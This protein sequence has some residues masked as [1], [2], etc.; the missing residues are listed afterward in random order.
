MTNM[1][2]V[3]AALVLHENGKKITSDGIIA[4]LK[5]AGVDEIDEGFA[6]AVANA[7][8]SVNIE[9]LKS[10]ATMV[11]V[12][13]TAAP[14]APAEAAPAEEEKKEEKKEEAGPSEEEAAAGLAALFG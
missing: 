7:L 8:S 11:P 1:S 12:A 3:Y 5:A 13:A 6:K 2:Y 9:E 10:K 14:A 4:I